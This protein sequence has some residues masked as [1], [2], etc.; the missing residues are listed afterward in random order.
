MGIVNRELF[1]DAVMAVFPNLIFCW[2]KFCS[3][4]V[5]PGLA[6][7][8]VGRKEDTTL[9]PDYLH[10][11]N[12]GSDWY[13][14]VQT[15]MSVAEEFTTLRFTVHRGLSLVLP[16]TRMDLKVCS[17]IL[18]PAKTRQLS[19]FASGSPEFP[20]QNEPNQDRKP[21]APLAR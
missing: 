17:S 10:P 2:K 5:T 1:H 4:K 9:L 8:K 7:K 11:L 6:R 20:S 18:I 12:S 14:K 19:G 15:T 3:Q 16:Q 21:L 13:R